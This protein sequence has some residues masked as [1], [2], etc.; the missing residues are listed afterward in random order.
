MTI[1]YRELVTKHFPDKPEL[2]V[3]SPGQSAERFIAHV[4]K[5]IR[6]C[7]FE[8]QADFFTDCYRTTVQAWSNQIPQQS[9]DL[10]QYERV[11]QQFAVINTAPLREPLGLNGIQTMV[12]NIALASNMEERLKATIVTPQQANISFNQASR[13]RSA[14]NPFVKAYS[15]VTDLATRLGIDKLEYWLIDLNF[16]SFDAYNDLYSEHESEKIRSITN[17]QLPWRYGILPGKSLE[18]E[19]LNDQMQ[20]MGYQNGNPFHFIEQLYRPGIIPVILDEEHN[21]F[22]IADLGS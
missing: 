8:Q 13:K 21:E 22:I 15:D 14:L 6:G 18:W 7:D 10:L 4:A 5:S 11:G 12:D 19:S 17:L 16:T 20:Q 3:A 2:A 9:R 1:E